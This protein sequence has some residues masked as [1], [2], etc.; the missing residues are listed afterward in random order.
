MIGH[1]IYPFQTIKY[2]KSEKF[3]DCWKKS[4]YNI[5]IITITYDNK[6]LYKLN[7]TT[8]KHT[9]KEGDNNE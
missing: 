2:K 9:N 4:D 6:L 5:T 7:F 3:L 8:N 1:K